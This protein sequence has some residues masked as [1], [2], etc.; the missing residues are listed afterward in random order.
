MTKYE[1]NLDG[2][3]EPGESF[4]GFDEV[5]E[6]QKILDD[7][8][9]ENNKVFTGRG[10]Y[11]RYK[12][13]A[14]GKNLTLHVYLKKLTFG[15]RESRPEEKRAQFSAALDR[16]GFV[17]N[18]END[19]S[20]IIALYKRQEYSETVLCA[21]DIK[22]WGYNIGRA[23]NCFINVRK[24]ALAL[25]DGFSQHQTAIGQIVCCFQPDNFSF[26]LE[27]KS[28]LHT[29]FPAKIL[30][31]EVENKMLYNDQIPKFDKLFQTIMDIL[32][33]YGE[34]SLKLMETETGKRHNLSELA[35][36][37]EHNIAEGKRTELGY[38]LAWAR[39]YLKRAGLIDNP[40]RGYWV[41]TELG[42]ITPID[43]SQIIKIATEKQIRTDYF[44][45]IEQEESSSEDYGE[46]DNP[47]DPNLVDI[48]TKTSSLDILL[49]RLDRGEIDLETS[50][51][52]KAGLWNLT[53]QSRLIESILIKFPL[54]AFY[55]DGSN[56]D[57][58]LIVD[59]LQRL[60]TLD[61]FKNKLA[62]KLQGLEFLS[63]LNG[64]SFNELPGNLQRR[65]E[66]FE[67]TS[68]IIAPGT[69][70]QLKYIV[71]NRVNT[72]G[73]T[74]TTQ[75]IRNALN[76]GKP[77]NFIKTLSE[78]ESF[79]RATSYSI[80]PD[81]MMDKE[82]ITRFCSFYLLDMNEY[83][84]DLE[85][86]M[87]SCMERIYEI[88]ELELIQ[89]KNNFDD[90]MKTAFEIFENDA[91][92]KRYDMNDKR[93]PIN[94]ALFE[95]WSVCLCNLTEEQRKI[96]LLRKDI[97]KENFIALLC[98]DESFDWSISAGTS[99]KTRVRKR[100][101]EINKIIQSTLKIS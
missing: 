56:D 38:Q 14:N 88:E 40:Q 33:E 83:N 19:I 86:F 60:S 35:I 98:N 11:Y 39:F 51:Q 67:T 71:F 26:Y 57:K 23:F 58:W 70:K 65:I 92:R 64:S 55:F 8:G 43:I 85:A 49:K 54:P 80:N 5:Y 74:L 22:D 2:S 17:S 50:F 89:L 68:Y 28:Q 34:V 72:G 81:R 91:F 99:D 29:E 1:A 9:I 6:F 21:W 93:K 10:G 84:S 47:F 13:L 79:K 96:L 20:L 32:I 15:G 18:S 95:A 69:P 76:Q 4:T 97:L 87:N 30:N 73:L 78:L 75:E 7:L 62:F 44:E 37:I 53:K 27:N 100:F 42:R 77:A 24:V 3:I 45:E 16:S 101:E 36:S 94:K 48:K 61:S 46:I 41:I 59:G 82:Y 90:S 31:E 63:Q 52:R 66:E 12:I 25:K